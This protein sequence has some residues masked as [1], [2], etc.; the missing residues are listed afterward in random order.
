MYSSRFK[1]LAEGLYS[2]KYVQSV[3]E[4]NKPAVNRQTDTRMVE[5]AGGEGLVFAPIKGNY[6]T[7][8]IVRIDDPARVSLVSAGNSEG[9]LLE[10][11][12][13]EHAA[14]GGINASGF[15]DHERRGD[16]WG[17]TLLDGA[18]LSRCIEG[19]R[20]VMGG[21]SRENKL[22]VGYFTEAEIEL[23]DY[24]WAVEFGPLLIVNGVKSELTEFSGGLSPRTAMGQTGDGAVLLVVVDGRRV[25]SIGATYKDIQTILYANGA[26]NAIGL[27]GGSS[28]SM[29]YQG[30][31]VNTPSEGDKGRMLPNA[32][33]F[34]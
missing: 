5:V 20:H 22:S 4:R 1:W 32:V 7:G 15:I 28:S 10:A 14:L 26:V 30:V 3:L 16:V 2:Q 31:L 29:V 21:F 19:D 11:L 24:L 23:Q 34:W 12:T 33:V 8:F 25:G 18:C 17:M 13:A 9:K 27:D 6:Y